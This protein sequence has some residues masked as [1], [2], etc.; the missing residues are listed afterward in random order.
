MLR[1]MVA[2][3]FT[4]LSADFVFLL[5]LLDEA[6]AAHSKI[7]TAGVVAGY[8]RAREASHSGFEEW[9]AAADSYANEYVDARWSSSPLEG[10]RING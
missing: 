1:M 2:Q 5:S 10:D 7:A 3:D 6:R 9:M 8:M 4:P